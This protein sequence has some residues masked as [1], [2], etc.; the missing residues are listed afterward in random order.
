MSKADEDQPPIP[1]KDDRKEQPPTPTDLAALITA[2]GALADGIQGELARDTTPKPA[3]PDASTGQ[4][5][6]GR[7]TNLGPLI[8]AAQAQVR[9]LRAQLKVTTPLAGG[10]AVGQLE[11]NHPLLDDVAAADREPTTPSES[12]FIPESPDADPTPTSAASIAAGR[13][14]RRILVAATVVFAVIVG[15]ELGLRY[16]APAPAVPS[17]PP[18]TAP[19]QADAGRV[20]LP[21]PLSDAIQAPPPG[22]ADLPQARKGSASAPASDR[23]RAGD[24]TPPT[25][26][27]PA[28]TAVGTGG[29]AEV[30][31][32]PDR[33]PAVATG[34]APRPTTDA[35][36]AGAP[37]PPATTG[38][39][40]I[41][42]DVPTGAIS[43]SAAARPDVPPP[44]ADD[45]STLA[46]RPAAVLTRVQPHTLVGLPSDEMSSTVEVQVAVTRA[47]RPDRVRAISG[48]VALR[49]AAED[50]VARWTFQPA[51]AG[52]QPVDSTLRVKLT[53]GP[54]LRDMRYR[55]RSP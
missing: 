44:P 9:T 48:P 33:T 36:T 6:A 19:D 11:E 38:A 5:T 54:A 35:P 43:P 25:R 32:V 13:W 14:P 24:S 22:L 26:S 3:A 31:A 4:P 51:L 28:T 52:G 30:G 23:A 8:D 17:S 53:F 1:Q 39:P 45:A 47:G 12:A 42:S 49:A 7:E 16:R 41:P 29:G 27:R 37:N 15:R 20:P 34:E 46:T 40:P 21:A 50:T 2:L 10:P 18:A 55:R